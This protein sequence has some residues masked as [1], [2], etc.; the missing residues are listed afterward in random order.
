M[1]AHQPTKLAEQRRHGTWTELCSPRTHSQT[2]AGRLVLRL[3]D[4]GATPESLHLCQ[5][6]HNSLAIRAIKKEAGKLQ[7]FFLAPEPTHSQ[8][9]HLHFMLR[10]SLKTFVPSIVIWVKHLLFTKNHVSCC[11]SHISLFLKVPVFQGVF[12]LV[13]KLWYTHSDTVRQYSVR[14]RDEIFSEFQRGRTHDPSRPTHRQPLLL[15]EDS[16]KRAR[17]KLSLLVLWRLPSPGT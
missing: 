13:G 14:H 6:Q 4:S 9:H 2:G 11:V 12:N 10:D 7:G 17:Q 8:E 15:I 3:T 1:G 5:F 16:P